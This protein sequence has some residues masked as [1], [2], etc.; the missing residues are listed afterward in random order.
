MKW[1]KK[2]F[3]YKPDGSKWWA[4]SYA[5][6]PTAEILNDKIIRTYYSGLDENNFGRIGYVDLDIENP[7]SILNISDSPLLEIGEI[8]TF[9]DC[10]VVPSCLIQVKGKRYLY[11]VGYQ[12]T[13][14]V[15]YMLYIGL[16]IEDKGK[17]KKYSKVPILDRTNDEP[18]SRSAPYI[19]YNEGI[20]KMWYWTCL[21]WTYTNNRIHYNNVIKYAESY[22]AIK[23]KICDRICIEPNWG[24]EYSVGRPCVIY[25]SGRYR[26]WYSIRSITKGY[27]IG[28]A[29]SRNGIDWTRKDQDVGI[30]TS[31]IG[32]DSE[33]ICYPNIIGIKGKKYMFYNGNQH[34]KTG[35]GYAVLEE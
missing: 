24:D 14:K 16:A 8:G 10:G 23:W 11:Y 15:P 18:Y 27:H 25:D 20:Y 3:I 17:F 34:G 13:E 6:M 30:S 28:Y 1:K 12:R 21:K 2:G 5:N 19:I 26:I 4:K 32:W 7:K 35:F 29:E 9:D 22:D 31:K 33:I